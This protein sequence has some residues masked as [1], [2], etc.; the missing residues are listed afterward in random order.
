MTCAQAGRQLAEL[1]AAAVDTKPVVVAVS[2]AGAT[3][4]SEVATALAAP[5]DILA[6]VRLSV[7]GRP[8]S[9]FG[10]VTDDE[11]TLLPD[12]IAA[13]GL[14]SEYVDRLIEVVRREAQERAEDWRGTAPAIDV[15]GRPVV[16]VDDGHSDT[17]AITTAAGVL[18][19]AGASEVLFAAPTATADLL[20]ALRPNC[21]R[22]ILLQ[23]PGDQPGAV[24]CAPAFPQATTGDVRA[25]VRRSRSDLTATVED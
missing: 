11:V 18:R 21:S 19:Q 8:H 1:V 22:Q 6:T 14:P 16:L 25:M 9:L 13:L 2:P 10:A 12:R 20:A 15:W 24:L 4:A 17:V 7:P 23:A 5:L 3:I